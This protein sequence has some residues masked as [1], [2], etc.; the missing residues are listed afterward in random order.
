MTLNIVLLGI[1]VLCAILYL[2]SKNKEQF[3]TDINQKIL[4]P[5]YKQS[6]DEIIMLYI[7]K[8]IN[9]P[10]YQKKLQIMKEKG[11]ETIIS[12]EEDSI[13]QEALKNKLELIRL[14]FE[15]LN[16]LTFKNINCPILSN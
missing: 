12:E 13:N 16:L 11:E 15:A 7:Q 10:A 9:S 4:Q 3:T 14:N 5:Y 6:D 2:Y 1:V 8:N